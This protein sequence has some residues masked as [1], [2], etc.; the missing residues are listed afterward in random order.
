MLGNLSAQT[1]KLGAQLGVLSVERPG[2]FRRGGNL[3]RCGLYGAVCVLHRIAP[4]DQAVYTLQLGVQS[5]LVALSYSQVFSSGEKRGVGGVPVCVVSLHQAGEATLLGC[6]F[7]DLA[8]DFGA[9]FV[10]VDHRVYLFGVVCRLR[11]LGQGNQQR[12]RLNVAGLCLVP[13]AIPRS[14]Y[15]CLAHVASTATASDWLLMFEKCHCLPFVS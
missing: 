8:Q 5:Y 1:L 6:V 10:R 13:N 4:I 2:C 15:L 9:F 7:I 12:G 14:L 11:L 3:L